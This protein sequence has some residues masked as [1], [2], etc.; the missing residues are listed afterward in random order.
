MTFMSKFF[1]ILFITLLTACASLPNAPSVM[2]L[3]GTGLSFD[4]FRQ[5]DAVC[6]QY[7]SFEV[8]GVNSPNP[9]ATNNTIAGAAVGTAVG[10][11]TGAAIGGGTGAAI[12]AGSGLVAGGAIGANSANYSSYADQQRYDDAYIQCMYAKGHQ[13]PVSGQFTGTSIQNSQFLESSVPPPPPPH[14]SA[15]KPIP[16]PPA[17]NPPPPPPMK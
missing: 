15:S 12:G 14:Y 4:Q 7:A 16:L 2:V 3:P 10:A 9:A 1:L 5:D 8:G 17:G 6:K 13:V 11:L